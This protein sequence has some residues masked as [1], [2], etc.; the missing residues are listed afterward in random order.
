MPK[1]TLHSRRRPAKKV[2]I[3]RGF[4]RTVEDHA[5]GVVEPPEVRIGAQL[6]AVNGGVVLAGGEAEPFQRKLDEARS[7]NPDNLANAMPS[8]A[9]S[10]R[11]LRMPRGG[12]L[13]IMLAALTRLAAPVSALKMRSTP[14]MTWRWIAFFST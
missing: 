8:S 1:A 14:S 12:H 11:S 4:A 5:Q 2:S 9:N 3:S 13:K 7:I 10:F 6:L